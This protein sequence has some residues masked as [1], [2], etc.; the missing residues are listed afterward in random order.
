MPFF[1]SPFFLLQHW[2]KDERYSSMVKDEE[3]YRA[4]CLV[5]KAT[6]EVMKH[7]I[8]DSHPVRDVAFS[9]SQV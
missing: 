1:V 9:F 2:Y 6:N 8:A 7:S 4:F 5:N 3:G